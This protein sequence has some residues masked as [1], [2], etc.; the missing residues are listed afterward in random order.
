MIIFKIFDSVFY[1]ILSFPPLISLA[2][3]SVFLATLI[4]TLNK[5]FVKRKVLEEIKQKIEETR[6][7]LAKAQREGDKEKINK[8]LNELMKINSEYMRYSLK[9]LL[10][11]FT[12][13]ILF[14]PWLN[15]RFKGLIVAIL[16]FSLP[17]IGSKLNWFYWYVFASLVVGWIIKK[18]IGE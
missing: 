10:I 18:M 6:E 8:F 15:S 9:V 12:V 5:I 3:F 14:L 2:L 16:P 7:M 17:I 1:P 4:V 13:I 11:S